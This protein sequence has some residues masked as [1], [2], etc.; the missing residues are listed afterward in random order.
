MQAG[1]AHFNGDRSDLA[2]VAFT[3]DTVPPAAPDP[4]QIQ[5]TD[6]EAGTLTVTG[7]AGSVEPNAVL[8]I[9]N[10]RTGESVTVTA[11]SDGSFTAQIAARAGDTLEIRLTDAAGNQSETRSLSVGGSSGSLP[12]DPATVAPPLT[13]TGITR[14]Q[15]ATAFLYRGPNPIQTGIAEGTIEP[16]RAAVIRGKVLSRDNQP[17][18]GVT[19]M[20]KDH[21]EFGQTLSRSDGEFDMAVNGGGLLTINYE[22]PGY[23]PAQR[24]VQTPWQDFAIA[25]EVVLVALDAQVTSI[26]LTSDAPIQVAQGSVS[27]DADGSRQATML[28]PEGTQATMTLPDGTTQPLTNLH[29]R[30]TEYTVGTNGPKAMPGPLP[31]TSGYTYAVELSVD[32]AL[33]ASAARVDFSQSLPV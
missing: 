17:L 32:E 12:P 15:E 2:S 25:E 19:I 13:E 22:K 20:I 21:P 33:A 5:V 31:P 10:T 16:S 28:F 27:T 6:P 29:V 24:Q 4:T 11:N 23:L 8:I 7:A 3:V 26:D 18:S 9:T 14:M 1:I 30:A